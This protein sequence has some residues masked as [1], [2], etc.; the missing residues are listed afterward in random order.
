MPLASRTV[1]NM[2]CWQAQGAMGLSKLL[3]MLTNLVCHADVYHHHQHRWYL[4]L[5][6]F[7][8]T[9]LSALFSMVFGAWNSTG[10]ESSSQ[11]FHHFYKALIDSFYLDPSTHWD[12]ALAGAKGIPVDTPC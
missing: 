6:G 2:L 1:D 12:E 5:G 10:L 11:D 7:K 8:C 9:F 4:L 3:P